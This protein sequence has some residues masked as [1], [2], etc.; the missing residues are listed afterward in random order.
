MSLDNILENLWKDHEDY[1]AKRKRAI[2]RGNTEYVA[3]LD[4]RIRVTQER[5]TEARK[6]ETEKHELLEWLEKTKAARLAAEERSTQTTSSRGR[7]PITGLIHSPAYGDWHRAALRFVKSNS[8]EDYNEMLNL[9]RLEHPL[10]NLWNET[11]AN[12]IS[13]ESQP[14]K[15]LT[16]ADIWY[17]SR[18]WVAWLTVVGVALFIIV[19][20]V[21]S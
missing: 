1:S 6:I 3:D 17:G 16:L 21:N 7:D 8:I 15:A 13:N 18:W 12:Q 5:I 11:E 2:W 10:P 4:Q 14:A 19:S 9:V 20:V